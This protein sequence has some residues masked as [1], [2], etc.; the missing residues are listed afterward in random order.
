MNLKENLSVNGADRLIYQMILLLT[1][2]LKKIASGPV[3]SVVGTLIAIQF[4]LM[5]KWN[6][7]NIVILI[8]GIVMF[9][10]GYMEGKDE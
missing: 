10:A 6:V 3:Q 1:D 8:F 2:F 5:R 9:L 4:V 7:N